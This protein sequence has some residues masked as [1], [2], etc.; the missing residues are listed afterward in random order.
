ME[1]QSHEMVEELHQDLAQ[2][3]KRH[4]IAIETAWRSF[5][6]R[7]RTKCLKAGAADGAV[8]KHPTDASLGNVYKFVPE[9]NLRDITEPGSDFLLDH[10]KHR[11]TQSLVEQYCNGV[12]GGPGDRDFIDEMM[13]TKRLRHVNPF[14]NCYTTFME[15]KYGHSFKVAPAH[16]AEV[17]ADL[18]FAVNAGALIPQS[19][20]ELILQRQITLLQVLSVLIDDILDEGSKTRTRKQAPKATKE[21]STAAVSKFNLQEA[22]AK[23][24]LADLAT[25]ARDQTASFEEQLILLRTE[26]SVLASMVNIRFF[27]RPELVADERGR[28]LPVHTDKYISAAFF[29]VIQTTIQAASIWKYITRLLDLLESSQTDKLYRTILLQELSN[30]CH[31]EY[32]RTQTAFR[33][34]V[35]IGMGSKRFKRVANAYDNAGNARISIKGN[36]EEL[37]R[38]DPQLHYLLRLCQPETTY[39]K[40]IDWMSKLSH[41][42][43]THPLE[44]EK[45]QAGESGSQYDLAVIIA[46]IQD[47]SSVVSLPAAS[48]KKGLSFTSRL[49]DLEVELKQLK[50]QIDL[51]DFAVPIDNLLEP[52]MAEGALKTLDEFVTEK[53]GSKM[54]FLYQ[55]QIE[56]C[57]P[58]LQN[59]YEQAK[60]KL[61]KNDK[62]ELFL[63]VS[64]PKDPEKRLEHRKQKEKTRPSHS[65]VY[66]ITPDAKT[67]PKEEQPS[68]PQKIKVSAPT[69]DLFGVLFN[70]SESRGSVNWTAFETAMAELGFSVLP[71]FGSVYCFYPP[72]SMAIRRPITI[73]RPH[74]SEI[75][76]YATLILARRL[77]RVYGWDAHT[78][79]VS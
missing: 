12:G 9:L 72:E 27:S 1:A 8:L 30:I 46:F 48:R 24:T 61:E 7:Q 62:V 49:Q 33:R 68:P 18:A 47:L 6:R 70:K 21:G 55:D 28:V 14:K 26:P 58:D 36:P 32:A 13:R 56:E 79:E 65:S 53:T 43:N 4:A 22:P 3:Y 34:Q 42:Y 52:G 57:F 69:A 40:A 66:E 38:T 73:H 23:L 2:K 77:N 5:D 51:R 63:P 75:E 59:Q 44:R 64:T 71:R 37:T 74:V 45:L 25:A 19:Q 35:S 41:L 31:F 10:L 76:G 54:G 16:E 11:A 50:E 67:P 20:G 29:E 17:L 60:A 78:F 15:S 39:S